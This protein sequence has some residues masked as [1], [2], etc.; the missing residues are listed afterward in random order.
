MIKKLIFALF[1]LVLISLSSCFKM[2][3]VEIKEIKSVKLIEFSDKGLQVES[4]IRIENPNS[5]DIKV[6]DSDFH[7]V[8]NNREIGH[9][10]ISSDLMIPAS[11]NDFHTLMLTSAHKDLAANAIPSLIAITATGKDKLNFK[12]EG[13]IVGKVWW[14]SKK[15]EVGHEGEVDLK[16]Y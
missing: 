11:S 1:G 7:V 6:V 10:H 13:F 5:F 15:V 14:I 16:L 3:E 12:V 4:N 2:E 9:A 8:V